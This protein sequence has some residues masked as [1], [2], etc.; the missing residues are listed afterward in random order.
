M[1]A[2]AEARACRAAAAAWRW[3]GL[4]LGLA[5]SVPVV[6]PCGPGQSGWEGERL[7]YLMFWVPVTGDGD[8][9]GVRGQGQRHG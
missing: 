6:A 1:L 7:C 2:A 5:S 8:I 3:R 4:G 9:Q